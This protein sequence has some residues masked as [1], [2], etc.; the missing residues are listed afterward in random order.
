MQGEPGS[1][2]SRSVLRFAQLNPGRDDM[3]ERAG[4]GW[5]LYEAAALKLF[6]TPQAGGQQVG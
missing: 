4:R 5:F 6:V 3:I 1:G 2:L